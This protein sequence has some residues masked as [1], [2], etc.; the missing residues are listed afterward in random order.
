MGA[1]ALASAAGVA[2]AAAVHTNPLNNDPL[3][4]EAFEHFYNLDYDGAVDR[5]GR[6]HDQH[7]GD[8]QPTVLLLEAVVF[9]E[10]YR[11]DLLDTTFYANDGFLTGRH[12][13]QE[14]PK[15]RDRILGLAAEVIHE[16]GWR[17]NKNPNDVDALYAR[18]LARSL[19]C[20][21]V[22]MV[23]RAYG[24]GFRLA[25]RAKDDC[26]RVLQIDPDY[27]DAKLVTGVYEY[28]V[29]ALPWPFKLLI[30]FA[31]I[32]GSKTRGLE[33]LTDDGNRGPVTSVEARTTIALFLRREGRYK[34]AIQVVRK[35]KSEYPRD[36]LFNL[37]EANLRKDAGEGMAAVDAYRA[38]LTANAKPG[39][40]YAP[41][42]ELTYFGLGEALRGQRH[43]ADAARSYEQAAEAPNVG[44]E[45]RIRS[46]LAAGECRDLNGE[47]PLAVK[48]YQAAIDAGPTTSRA[49]TAR[50]RLRSP[51][52]GN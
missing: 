11:Q 17:L 20:T 23:E 40:F 7:P 46:L 34:E 18:G 25:T 3:V 28:V 47:R 16:A 49:D 19:E 2:R 51:Y 24:T 29:G 8:P 6:F 44:P 12:A 45:L 22:A 36:Y 21:Y 37:E 9:Q 1:I 32:T 27:V 41:R 14:D 31:G 30:G 33:M 48:D 10:L 15:I 50:K 43:Y 39:Y 42:L 52:A 4:K 5:F 26:V 38:I 13:T 35:L